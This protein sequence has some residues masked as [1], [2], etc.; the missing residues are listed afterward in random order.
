MDEALKNR[1]G[2]PVVHIAGADAALDGLHCAAAKQGHR[3]FFQGQQPIIFEK[4]HALGGNAPGQRGVR[5][6][7]LR[8]V[9]IQG[10]CMND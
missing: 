9:R 5:S 10:S 4:H 6:L 1:H 7:P 2:V 8:Q 3:R